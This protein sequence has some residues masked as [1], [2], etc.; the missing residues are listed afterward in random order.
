MAVRI[1]GIA[2]SLSR[3]KFKGT[4]RGEVEEISSPNSMCA[5][6]A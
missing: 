4:A 3:V 6:E 2:S 1:F 5:D